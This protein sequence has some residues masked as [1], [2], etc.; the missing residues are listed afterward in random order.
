VVK[1]FVRLYIDVEA[2]SCMAWDQYIATVNES[3]ERYGRSRQH[4][5]VVLPIYTLTFTHQ[6]SHYKP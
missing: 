4:T 2:M 1:A 5:T 3:P 6:Q